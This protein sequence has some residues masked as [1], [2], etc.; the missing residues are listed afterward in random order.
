V[1]S[2]WRQKKVVHFRKT[3][4]KIKQNLLKMFTRRSKYDRKEHTCCGG[5]CLTCRRSYWC[6]RCTSRIGCNYT[7]RCQISIGWCRTDSLNN[8][9]Q[10]EL[11]LSSSSYSSR[12]SMSGRRSCCC[13][14]GTGQTWIPNIELP[15]IGIRDWS[16]LGIYPNILI[17][18]Y[19]LRNKSVNVRQKSL[20]LD[21]PWKKQR[22]ASNRA[23]VK[24]N[25]AN[26]CRM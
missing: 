18:F 8:M 3:C 21:A 2:D 22:R 10:T 4:K 11:L 14:C 24:Y 9:F 15:E 1:L 12:H 26:R 17:L 16:W 23:R 6:S 19:S 13:W 5:S 20:P 25:N 7:C